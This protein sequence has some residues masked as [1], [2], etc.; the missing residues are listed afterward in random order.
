MLGRLGGCCCCCS[1]CAA[2]AARPTE[3]TITT[4]LQITFIRPS[5]FARP[6]LAAQEAYPRRCRLV[7][8]KMLRSAILWPPLMAAGDTE[9]DGDA[10][11]SRFCVSRCRGPGD[12]L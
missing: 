6:V 12:H 11:D 2:A 9:D 3:S 7:D 8:G 10:F 4:M 1:A 5:S